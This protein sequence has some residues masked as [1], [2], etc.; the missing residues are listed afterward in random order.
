MNMKKLCLALGSCALLSTTAAL[1]DDEGTFGDGGVPVIEAPA[2]GDNTRSERIL[3]TGTVPDI[4]EI[5]SG[6]LKI[7]SLTPAMLKRGGL[8]GIG[9]LCLFSN[10][11]RSMVLSWAGTTGELV[12][13]NNSDSS[14][15]IAYKF[16]PEFYLNDATVNEADDGSLVIVPNDSGILG[17]QSCVNPQNYNVDFYIITN[18]GQAAAVGKYS[19]TLTVTLSSQASTN[20][21]F[22]V[23]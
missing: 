9:Q 19:G 22:V 6:S 20:P 12:L 23:G 15:K 21:S 13:I 17:D 10:T 2:T 14:Q 7:Y 8:L 5:S 16:I 1:A 4:V 11:G 18:S 3:V